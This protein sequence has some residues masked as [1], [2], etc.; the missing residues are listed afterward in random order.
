[1]GRLYNVDENK[2]EQSQLL[3]CFMDLLNYIMFGHGYSME[4]LLVVAMTSRPAKSS[5]WPMGTWDPTLLP[6]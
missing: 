3:I 4:L 1:M 2:T 6:H 5:T